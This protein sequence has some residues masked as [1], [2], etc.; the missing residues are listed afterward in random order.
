MLIE[1]GVA[2]GVRAVS[3]QRGKIHARRTLRRAAPSQVKWCRKV[4][5]PEPVTHDGLVMAGCAH[6]A[7]EAQR[8]P[9]ASAS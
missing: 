9:G 6:R 3:L 7:H 5:I 1:M 2:M 4:K 8:P